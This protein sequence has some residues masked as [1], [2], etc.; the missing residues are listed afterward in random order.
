MMTQCGNR[1][2][3]VP[4]GDTVIVSL[5]QYPYLGKWKAHLTTY[6]ADSILITDSINEK[7][8]VLQKD[9]KLQAINLSTPRYDSWEVFDDSV[10]VLFAHD[11]KGLTIHDTVQISNGKMVFPNGIDTWYKAIK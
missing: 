2:N 6:N 3:N 4:L 8:V 9:G 10:L 1:T 5:N 7:G 11:A